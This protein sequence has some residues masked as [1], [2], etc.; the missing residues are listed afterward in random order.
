MCVLVSQCLGAGYKDAARTIT[1]RTLKCAVAITATNAFL[2]YI[3]RHELVALYTPD[4][5]VQQLAASLLIFGVIYHVTDAC[6]SV[7]NF[8][9]RGYRVTVLPMIL[10]GVLL[11]AVGLGGGYWLGFGAEDFGGPYGAAG[12][13][14]ATTLGLILAGISLS[15]LALYVS[16]TRMMEDRVPIRVVKKTPNANG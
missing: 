14:A 3:F 13:W 15:A 6:Q 4:V 7:S 5:P 9:L 16:R 2:L 10:Y 12:F 11:W 1:V 8:A